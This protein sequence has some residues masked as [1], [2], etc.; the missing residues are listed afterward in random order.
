FLAHVRRKAVGIVLTPEH[1]HQQTASSTASFLTHL[2]PPFASS[3][4]SVLAP[5]P[6][7]V[8]CGRRPRRRPVPFVHTTGTGRRGHTSGSISSGVK[9]TP[10]L[11]RLSLSIA[12]T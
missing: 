9:P 2:T 4:S 5:R 1:L 8:L 12:T 11:R 6:H 3:P 10:P 7:T